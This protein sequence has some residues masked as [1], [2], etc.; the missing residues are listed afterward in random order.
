MSA[1][2]LYKILQ[3]T[4]PCVAVVAALVVLGLPAI[5]TDVRAM[6]DLPGGV[7]MS[8]LHSPEHQ[9]AAAVRV[10]G[11][12]DAPVVDMTTWE[13]TKQSSPFRRR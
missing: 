5:A 9:T 3:T 13:E 4:L 8:D 2:P 12:T 10:G 6:P 11:A 7:L 1:K